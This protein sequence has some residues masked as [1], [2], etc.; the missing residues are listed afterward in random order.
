MS[1]LGPPLSRMAAIGVVC[2]ALT[3]LM[4]LSVRPIA[5]AENP[6]FLTKLTLV[7]LAILNALVLRA[8]PAWRRALADGGE[9]VSLKAQALLSLLLWMGA[10]LAGRWIGFLQ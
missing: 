9:G 3:G 7:A 1:A 10:V 2:A 8:S 6:A 5:Y 4:L